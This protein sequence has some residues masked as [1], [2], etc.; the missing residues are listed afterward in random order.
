MS[1]N[2]P[3]DDREEN[4]AIKTA[5]YQ[6]EA[7][8][9]VSEKQEKVTGKGS[10]E[11]AAPPAPAEVDDSPPEEKEHEGY[12]KHADNDG[13]FHLKDLSDGTNV[14]E[15][16][17]MENQARHPAHQ[18]HELAVEEDAPGFQQSAAMMLPRG[19]PHYTGG[20]S[21]AEVNAGQSFGEA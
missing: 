9:A 19:S 4:G 14:A 15:G 16:E 3:K 12:K 13:Q 20:G 21:N 18:Q 8:K 6:E 2:R 1:D 10:S 7:R 5:R 17:I 11:P